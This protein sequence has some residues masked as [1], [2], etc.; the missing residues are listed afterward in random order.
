[1]LQGGPVDAFL[2]TATGGMQDLNTLFSSLLV[3]G[4]GSQAG[5]T[6]L[7]E[8][9]AINDEG[10]IVGEG[11]YY[12]GSTTYGAAFLLNTDMVPEP[13]AWLLLGLGG[14]ILLVGVK[15]KRLRSVHAS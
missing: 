2:Y 10:Q 6:D 7:I 11:D 9:T 1:M 8:A 13:P 15:M 14:L 4:T 12:N 3:S 5:F